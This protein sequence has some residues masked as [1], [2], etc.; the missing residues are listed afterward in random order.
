VSGKYYFKYK[1]KNNRKNTQSTQTRVAKTNFS[2]PGDLLKKT[3]VHQE[4]FF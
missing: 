2:K 1:K 4:F 3:E